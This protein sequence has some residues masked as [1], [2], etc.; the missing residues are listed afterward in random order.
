MPLVRLLRSDWAF[1]VVEKAE[2]AKPEAHA[3]HDAAAVKDALK[4]L[5]AVIEREDDIDVGGKDYGRSHCFLPYQ[6]CLRRVRCQVRG[7]FN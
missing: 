7:L 4:V 5:D 3:Q 2:E 1:K 6:G